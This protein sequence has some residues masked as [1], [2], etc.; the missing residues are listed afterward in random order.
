MQNRTANTMGGAQNW[1][2]A[3]LMSAFESNGSSRIS[4]GLERERNV[5]GFLSGH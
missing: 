2:A 4:A 1:A 5:P 3:L